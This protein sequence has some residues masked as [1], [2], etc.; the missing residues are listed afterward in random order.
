MIDLNHGSGCHYESPSRPPGVGV[1]VNAAIDVRWSIA[2]AQQ[3]PRDYC[4]ARRGLGREC[5]RQIQYDYLAVP[6]DEGRDFDGQTLR[7][8]EAGHRSRTLSPLAAR[9]GLRPAHD[10]TRGGQFG[11]SALDGRFAVTSTALIVGPADMRYPGALGTQGAR[12]RVLEGRGQARRA[13]LPSRSMR[14]RSRSTWPTGAAEPALFTA[15]NRDTFELHCELVAFDAALA[16]RDERPGAAGGA[17]QPSR[18]A[19]AACCGRSELGH[20]PRRQ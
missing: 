2:I 11:F 9:R 10:R 4:A 3:P 13:C 14:R 5:L 20:L 19:A 18:R 12:R 1:A 6:K 15:L 16:Q 7:I 17:R 8:F